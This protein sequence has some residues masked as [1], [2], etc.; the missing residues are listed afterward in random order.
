MPHVLEEWSLNHRTAREVL[1][2]GDSDVVVQGTDKLWA[3][4]GPGQPAPAFEEPLLLG[5][6]QASLMPP[7]PSLLICWSFLVYLPLGYDSVRE[8]T[9]PC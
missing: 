8:R 9:T 5:P 2:C 6:P 7:Y 4:G 1:P 3:P